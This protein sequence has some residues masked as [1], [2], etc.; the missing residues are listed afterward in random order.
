[1]FVNSP[2]AWSE[3]Q[4]GTTSGI[5]F[6][7]LEKKWISRQQEHYN[8]SRILIPV[9]EPR[10]LLSGTK[11]FA[12]LKSKME[13][14]ELFLKSLA[15]GVPRD[16]VNDIVEGERN[17]PVV[18]AN[19]AQMDV[20][21]FQEYD[22]KHIAVSSGVNDT[23]IEYLR[24]DATSSV[25]K[26]RC[27]LDFGSLDGGGGPI[28]QIKL[29][30]SNMIAVRQISSVKLLERKQ[31]EPNKEEL[32]IISSFD[33]DHEVSWIDHAFDQI[34]I[35]LSDNSIH[36]IDLIELAKEVVCDKDVLGS[37]KGEIMK[38]LNFICPRIFIAQT[39][40]GVYQI[41]ARLDE[42]KVEVLLDIQSDDFVEESMVIYDIAS[43]PTKSNYIAVATN[44]HAILL[45]TRFKQR[46]LLTFPLLMETSLYS[47]DFMITPEFEAIFVSPRGKH[48]CCK[49]FLIQLST[50]YDPPISTSLSAFRIESPLYTYSASDLYAA[51]VLQSID[52]YSEHKAAVPGYSAVKIAV[53]KESVLLL[54]LLEDGSLIH[55]HFRFNETN[56]IPSLLT[57]TKKVHFA[58]PHQ[59]FVPSKESTVRDI[60]MDLIHK[61]LNEK[62]K[63]NEFEQ[64]DLRI[65]ETETFCTKLDQV[66]RFVPDIINIHNQHG[67]SS[68]EEHLLRK[69]LLNDIIRENTCEEIPLPNL[70]TNALSKIVSER[71][72]KLSESINLNTEFVFEIP[73]LQDEGPSKESSGIKP[74][75][76]R[77][78]DSEYP[79]PDSRTALERATELFEIPAEEK[80]IKKQ[81]KTTKSGFR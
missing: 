4:L 31:V 63:S 32:V 34:A 60:K 57:L 23:R 28:R 29:L 50:S 64:M 35:A 20:K 27:F 69:K 22:E 58:L 49:Y 1:M 12:F 77:V 46:R 6:R 66:S 41:D 25:L 56:E 40:I 30:G 65:D 3:Q 79:E 45:D 24:Y 5:C 37:N 13:K 33:F 81:K 48:G 14:V 18:M 71:W 2:V 68:F 44:A 16:I 8:T 59:N 17:N 52:D 43:Y 47:V 26:S 42:P 53:S 78:T 19:T 39:R 62:S 70:N 10:I 61:Y 74:D 9:A 7:E 73:P 38:V 54:I 80:I 51:G 11:P 21:I 76:I 15:A 36:A 55:C 75:F 67:E 72:T